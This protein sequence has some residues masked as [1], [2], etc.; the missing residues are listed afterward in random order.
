[1]VAAATLASRYTTTLV[2]EAPPEFDA[3]SELAFGVVEEAL[4]AFATRLLTR[5][6][7]RFD[8]D[9]VDEAVEI[10]CQVERGL[11]TAAQ[12]D[13]RHL[14]R[15]FPRA[16]ATAGRLS[17]AEKPSRLGEQSRSAQ[18]VTLTPSNDVIDA[19]QDGPRWLG[20]ARPASS[21]LGQRV[22]AVGYRGG[23]KHGLRPAAML[24][25]RTGFP[26]ELAKESPDRLS[27]APCN[28][29]VWSLP[30][31]LHDRVALARHARHVLGAAALVIVSRAMASQSHDVRSCYSRV[32]AGRPG[33]QR[34]D[35]H[36]ALERDLL[37]NCVRR[38]EFGTRNTAPGSFGL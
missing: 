11:H 2:R 18:G 20:G 14:G 33:H 8:L 7:V 19:A 22:R 15:A 34:Q 31:R 21:R 37:V 3:L 26:A 30:G 24:R 27:R 5:G 36:A 1:V 12:A 38:L 29:A 10:F 16:A 6:V 17:C 28:G 13:I 35:V 32:C 23:T 9:P 4:I 25:P